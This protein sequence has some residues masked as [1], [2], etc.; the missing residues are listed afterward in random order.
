LGVVLVIVAGELW[1]RRRDGRSFAREWGAF[2]LRLLAGYAA[3]LLPLAAWYVFALPAAGAGEQ[4]WPTYMVAAYAQTFPNR[5]PQLG[6]AR[7]FFLVWLPALAG[8]GLALARIGGNFFRRTHEAS[9]A[10][11]GAASGLLFFP[12]YYAF[13]CV[14]LFHNDY[15]LAGQLWLAWPGL[16]LAALLAGRWTRAGFA[17]LLLPIALGA[18]ETLRTMSREEQRWGAQPLALPNGQQLWFRPDE[19][20][21]FGRL[22]AVLV[23]T[24][25][26]APR[27][28]VFLG[29]GGIHHFFLTRRVGRL[30]WFLPEFVRPWEREAVWTAILQ[31][32]RILVVDMGQASG[33]E[34]HGVVAL[35]LPLPRAMGERLLPHLRNPRHLDSVG[36]LLD[37]GP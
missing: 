9:A 24:G 7:E 32:E 27:L 15:A 34:S 19:A 33:R 25:S 26:P 23:Q 28:A 10:A 16:G 4:L 1:S 18:F 31:S 14:V 12:L 20:Q 8:I 13:G 2:A 30:W 17:L 21:H 35:W 22:Q 11:N 3:L 36:D 5:W 37:V 6:S 29:G